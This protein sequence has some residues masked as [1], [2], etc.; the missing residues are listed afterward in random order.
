MPQRFDATNKAI[1][2]G[3]ENATPKSAIGLID[4]WLGEI[5]KNEFAG[6]KGIHADLERL[7][8][9]LEKDEP[10][11]E[12]VQKIIGKLG[13]ATMKS[14]D[15]AGNDKVADQLRTL[16]ENLSKSGTDDE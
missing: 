15:K 14:A 12:T 9:E 7:K 1:E 6:S 13:P 10:K 11:G 5:E 16:G 3:L 4:A 2:K 8:K